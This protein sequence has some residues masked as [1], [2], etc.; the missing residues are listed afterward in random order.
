[1]PLLTHPEAATARDWIVTLSLPLP[2]LLDRAPTDSP[3]AFPL[4]YTNV[5]FEP[6][7]RSGKNPGIRETR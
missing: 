4:H 3:L 5:R 7:C 2:A 1:M 6:A